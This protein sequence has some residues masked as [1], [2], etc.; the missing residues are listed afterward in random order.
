ML[1]V[2][3]ATAAQVSAK[4]TGASEARR[5]ISEACEEYRPVARRAQIVYF[6]IA[7]LSTV[8]CMYQTSL[9]QVGRL[10]PAPD[11]FDTAMKGI[12]IFLSM[13][14]DGQQACFTNLWRTCSALY[15]V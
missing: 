9:A 1:A 12:A 13:G 8:N 4:L 15:L 6:L 11:T 14:S 3:K 10:G 7:Q 2:T 5:R